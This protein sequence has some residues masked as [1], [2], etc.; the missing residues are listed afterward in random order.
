MKKK[1][2]LL[3]FVIVILMTLFNFYYRPVSGNPNVTEKYK[4]SVSYVNNL[5][6]SD[7]MF[8]ERLLSED[9]YYIY[10]Q[11]LSDVRRGKLISNIECKQKGCGNAFGEVWEALMLDH[12][13]QLAFKSALARY[14]NDYNTVEL[15]YQRVLPLSTYFGT[16]RIEREMDII[17]RET[18]NMSEEEKILYVYNYV[19]SHNYDRIFKFSSSNQS[20]YS[21][22][23]KGS[24]V[25]AG[26]AK[27]SQIIF[28][29][30]GI[31]SYLV[32]GYNHMWNYVEY[33][34]K[35]YVFDAT[36]GA[37]YRDKT[38][39]YYYEGLGRTT[40]NKT[41]GEHS[42]MYPPIE[43]TTLRSIFGV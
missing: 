32:H 21:F 26:F 19:A 27:V 39:K 34:G 15:Q 2:I 10:E 22:F 5:Y 9:N 29:N 30:I 28:Q 35:Y 18:K 7:E 12:P 3:Y 1:R 20:I 8:K 33:K 11:I 6:Y 25:C 13:E 4:D 43:K 36:V 16:R 17:K 14:I 23:T 42:E 38:S 24:S 40:V 37:S 41:I 31:K